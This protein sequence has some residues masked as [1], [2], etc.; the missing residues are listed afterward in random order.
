MTAPLANCRFTKASTSLIFSKNMVY[1]TVTPSSFLSTLIIHLAGPL[2]FT[3]P[4]PTLQLLIARSLVSCSTLQF[5]PAPTS[6]SPSMCSPNATQM[7]PQLTMLPHVAFFAI[8]VG[9][10]THAFIM[11]VIAS[12]RACWPF[13][14][15]IGQTQLLIVCPYQAMPGFILEGWS[16]SF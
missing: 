9:P 12:M 7:P 5:A 14:M 10:S 6:P 3:H 15:Q 16:A 8:L 13:V 11:G 4:F 2:V 1:L